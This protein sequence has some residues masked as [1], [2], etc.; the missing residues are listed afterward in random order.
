M[1]SPTKQ[2]CLAE[3]A[4]LKVRHEQLET[5]HNKLKHELKVSVQY[6]NS[7]LGNTPAGVAILEGEDFRYRYINKRLA[8]INGAT[9]AAHLGQPLQEI[10]PAAAPQVIP[11]L[12]SVI[13]TGQATT[14]REFSTTMPTDPTENR[15]FIDSFFPIVTGNG[16]L[17]TVGVVVIEV[18]ERKRAELA[19]QQANRDLKK[20]G[21]KLDITNT[22]LQKEIK[23]RSAAERNLLQIQQQLTHLLRVHT[24][25]EMASGI[26]HELN[27]PLA[28]IV[29][30]SEGCSKLINEDQEDVVGVTKVL[31]N[32]TKEAMRCN[33]IIIRLRGLVTNNAPNT[34]TF[35]LKEV[36]DD[37]ISL[38]KSDLRAA[39]VKINIDIADNFPQLNTDKIQLSQ[40]IINLFANAMD[41]ITNSDAKHKTIDLSAQVINHKIIIMIKDQGPGV[42]PVL[43]ENLFDPYISS[44]ESGLGMGLTISR[45]I[46]ESLGG[47]L[48][49]KPQ[50]GFGAC[51]E[52]SLPLKDPK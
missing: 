16:D 17:T 29:N 18:T 32:I 4:E 26:A 5:E 2:A 6:L 41:A 28:A 43:K 46:I 22:Q 20:H 49:L 48:L 45:S 8:D 9:V 40:T 19:L 13:E 7:I 11:G 52:L 25:E 21:H 39:K 50:D 51:F 36:L 12:Q 38:M 24:I 33:D 44:K 15:W 35:K 3:L 34:E 27:Q 30:Y 37:V 14:S 10:I 31:G 23:E 42:A 1:Q 47:K